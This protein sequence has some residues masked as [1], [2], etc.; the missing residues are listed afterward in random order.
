MKPLR[1]NNGKN[2]R[3][4]IIHVRYRIT[5]TLTLKKYDGLNIVFLTHLERNLH[6]LGQLC[7]NNYTKFFR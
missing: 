7:I 3:Y 1:T 6:C 4:F 5:Y 2:K